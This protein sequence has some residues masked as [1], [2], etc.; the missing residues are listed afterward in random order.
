M[1]LVHISNLMLKYR[2][3]KE[4]KRRDARLSAILVFCILNQFYE[5]KHPYNL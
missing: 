1:V 2:S 5:K 3:G 4:H